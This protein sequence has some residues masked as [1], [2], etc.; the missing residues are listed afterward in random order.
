MNRVH[1]E[2]GTASIRRSDVEPRQPRHD[3]PDAEEEG[4]RLP[5]RYNRLS[6]PC[7]SVSVEV[8]PGCEAW[9][10]RCPGRP[11]LEESAT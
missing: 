3:A 8:L 7:C 9:C 4:W 6:C 10:S 5:L 2:V 1:Q 11:E